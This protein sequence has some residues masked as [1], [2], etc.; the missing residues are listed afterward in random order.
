MF[1]YRTEAFLFSHLPINCLLPSFFLFVTFFKTSIKQQW[2]VS[3]FVGI[4]LFIHVE[5]PISCHQS[6]A[7]FFF[8]RSFVQETSHKNLESELTSVNQSS[9]SPHI[10]HSLEFNPQNCKK[11]KK[12]YIYKDYHS[13]TNTSN[14]YSIL[15]VYM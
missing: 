3:F 13:S 1:Y 15:I 7:A 4:V 2:L 11:K 5:I 12:V 8:P 10:F 6:Y 14:K 9:I